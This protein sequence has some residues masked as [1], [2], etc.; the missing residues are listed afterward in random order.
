MKGVAALELRN[1][2]MMFASVM[3]TQ[4]SQTIDINGIVAAAH[5]LTLKVFQIVCMLLYALSSIAKILIPSKWSQNVILEQE[6]YKRQPSG[7]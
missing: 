1:N 7:S 6:S 3:M 4:V 2:V 5:S